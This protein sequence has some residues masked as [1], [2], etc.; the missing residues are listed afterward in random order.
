MRKPKKP[1]VAGYIVLAVQDG[2]VSACYMDH[3]H[4]LLMTFSGQGGT[5]FR[6]RKDAEKAIRAANKKKVGN[7]WE[8]RQHFIARLDE[9][10]AE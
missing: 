9:L 7:K 3:D 10:E 8:S 5:L 4:G 2:K 1:E 6:N